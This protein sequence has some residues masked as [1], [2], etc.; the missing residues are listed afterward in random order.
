MSDSAHLESG[1][2]SAAQTGEPES[3]RRSRFGP[4][5]AIESIKSITRAAL[6]DPENKIGDERF[7]A[8]L[9]QI[10]SL[11]QF[12]FEEKV[13]FKPEQ[14]P[15]IDLGQLNGLRY[16]ASGRAPTALE[17]RL[18]DEKLSTLASYLT[19]EL[20]QRIRIRELGAFFGLIPLIFLL[21]AAAVVFFYFLYP[22][23]LTRDTLQFDAAY[24]SSIVLWTLSQGGLGACA[25][26]GTRVAI[27]RAEGASPLQAIDEAADITDRN[28][29]KI[30]I[31]L[32]CLF[33]FLIGLP[34]ASPSL[35]KLQDSIFKSD[36]LS[37][38]DLALIF[39]PFLLGFSTNLVLAV[40]DRTFTAIRTFFGLPTGK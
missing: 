8:Q 40:L 3:P 4:Q 32:G 6:G 39:V 29:L 2:S 31:I 15:S 25:F 14:L 22:R 17:W 13:R 37:G 12:L 20:R 28:I 38:S 24:L 33:A 30:R 18:L 19:D 9:S 23:W 1:T 7:I 21:A 26:L 10:H 35:T 34:I 5:A 36:L 16:S 11:K 27:K